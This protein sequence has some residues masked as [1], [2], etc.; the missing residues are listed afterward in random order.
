MAVLKNKPEWWM[1]RAWPVFWRRAFLLTLPVS[2]PLW[3]TAV[4]VAGLCIGLLVLI[5]G[6]PAMGL[7]VLK[8][9]LWDDDTTPV[10]RPHSEGQ[11]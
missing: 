3:V 7:F 9:E 8:E 6:L 1:P 5:V 11:S 4:V 10:T 2:G